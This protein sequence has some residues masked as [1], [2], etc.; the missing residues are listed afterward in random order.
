MK[1]VITIEDQEGKVNVQCDHKAA[2]LIEFVKGRGRNLGAATSAAMYAMG[3]LT[4]AMARSREMGRTQSGIIVLPPGIQGFEGT[5][6]PL[7]RKRFD[8]RKDV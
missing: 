4:W 5:M 1:I 6:N 3:M 2:D 7:P 8:H